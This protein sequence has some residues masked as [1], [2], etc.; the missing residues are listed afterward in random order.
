MK[1]ATSSILNW[2]MVA[3][4]QPKT[5][6]SS[7]NRVRPMLTLASQRILVRNYSEFSNKRRL[8]ITPVSKTTSVRRSS[9]SSRDGLTTRVTASKR[10]LLPFAL[11]L[12]RSQLADTWFYAQH[13]P[14]LG[15]ES[16]SKQNKSQGNVNSK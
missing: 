7:F 1:L 14:L 4:R 16:V 11:D 2:L 10:H 3:T 12:Q 15:I 13:R 9:T 6:L 8:A 5:I